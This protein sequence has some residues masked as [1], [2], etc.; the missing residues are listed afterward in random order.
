MTRL[1]RLLPL[2]L[3]AAVATLAAF[4]AFAAEG[5]GDVQIVEVG[6]ALFPD[7]SYGLTLTEPRESVLTAKDVKVTEDGKPVSDLSVLSAASGEGIGTV[8]LIDSS[9]SMKGSIQAAMDAANAFVARNPGQ[10]ISI[11]F[12]NAVPAPWPALVSMRMSTGGPSLAWHSCR[13]A[14]NLKLCAGTTRSS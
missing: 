2:A 8:L 3:V 11:V 5:G 10:P 13:R 6:S 9:N 4:P 12:F 1:L 14:A 7:R